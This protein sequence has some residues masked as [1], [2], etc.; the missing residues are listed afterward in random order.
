MALAGFYRGPYRGNGGSGGVVTARAA[1]IRIRIIGSTDKG[2]IMVII[3]R[4]SRQTKWNKVLFNDVIIE[5]QSRSM[6]D[7]V[8]FDIDFKRWVSFARN[9]P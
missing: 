2:I 4:C 3:T 1:R 9:Y 7:K 6:S 5:I 8:G